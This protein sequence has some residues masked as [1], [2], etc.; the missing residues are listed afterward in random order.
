[1]EKAKVEWA[2]YMWNPFTGL[3]EGNG[4]CYS[5]KKLSSFHGDM[6]MNL[7]KVQGNRIG[8]VYVLEEQLLAENGQRITFPLG[9]A[10]TLYRYRMDV[11]KR[12][13]MTR[14]ILTCGLGD[15]FGRSVPDEVITEV[16]EAARKYQ[17]HH[18]LFITEFPE[19]YLEMEKQGILPEDDN[20][21][22][23]A[24][25]R[26]GGCPELKKLA[27]T[28]RHTYQVC[29]PLLDRATLEEGVEWLVIGPRPDGCGEKPP[30]AAVL[31]LVTQARLRDVPVFMSG[32]LPL[33][34]GSRPDRQLPAALTEKKPGE[35]RSKIQMARCPVCGKYEYKGKQVQLHAKTGRTGFG[36]VWA[37]LCPQCFLGLCE[38]W[39]IPEPGL[40]IFRKGETHDIKQK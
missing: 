23:G 29:E 6:R 14:N 3:D 40:D 22:F 24:A 32:G 38:E 8:K 9:E 17:N 35:V 28:G 11:P 27:A 37:W 12:W 13:K 25:V 36:T 30:Y 4:Y 26:K 18:Y 21:W 10:Q 19:R 1:M 31:D 33:P 7:L 39:E 16:F 15:L 20:F 34:K 2:E 5:R